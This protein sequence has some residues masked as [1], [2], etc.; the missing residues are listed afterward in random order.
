[1][2]SALQTVVTFLRL[3]HKCVLIYDLKMNRKP[4]NQSWKFP[5]M[6]ITDSLL[7]GGYIECHF[8]EL[9]QYKT[10]F[11]FKKYKWQK[12]IKYSPIF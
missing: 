8:Q 12:D 10:I 2:F 9:S 7:A 6:T 11:V 1:M 3:A 5:V 4:T